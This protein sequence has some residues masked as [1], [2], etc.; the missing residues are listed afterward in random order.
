M[1]N[2]GTFDWRLNVLERWSAPIV[3]VGRLGLAYV[4]V[5]DG[6]QAIVD[7]A[8]VGDYM[9][10]NGVSAS[11]LPLVIATEFGGGLLVAAGFLARW[12]GLALAGFCVLTA[13]LFHRDAGDIDQ[14]IHFQKDLAIAGGFLLLSAFG[15]GAWSL[16]GWRAGRSR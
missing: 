10:S 13:W 15:P 14:V 5:V 7:Y 16:D 12:A 11:L 2:G 4:F 6:W 1:A 9:Q 3:L 8:G